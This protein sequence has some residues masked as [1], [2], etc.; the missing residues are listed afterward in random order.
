VALIA[1][2]DWR[3]M[4]DWLPRLRRHMAMSPWLLL[5]DLRL[6]GMFL[7]LM[8]DQPCV[9]VDPN[10][11]PAS[12]RSGLQAAAE[13]QCHPV[14]DELR[15]RLALSLSGPPHSRPSLQFTDVELQCG[16]GVSLGLTNPEIGEALRVSEATVKSH[17]HRL[18]K[19]L[20]THRRRE[21]GELI[22]WA[23][24]PVPS[25]GPDMNRKG[26]ASPLHRYVYDGNGAGLP[27]GRGAGHGR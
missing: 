19:K 21:L 9:V 10:G 7:K 3:Q 5:A 4:A 11:D 2:L 20:E 17:R 23:L 27:D 1:A 26:G 14:A 8:E 24:A 25:G 18:M 15:D 16:C 13:R 6:A 22:D 12:L